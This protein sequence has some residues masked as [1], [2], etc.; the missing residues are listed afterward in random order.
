MKINLNI[1]TEEKT[2][3]QKAITEKNLIRPRMLPRALIRQASMSQGLKGEME[4]TEVNKMQEE[5]VY[6][7][8]K[9]NMC[10]KALW[11]DEVIEGQ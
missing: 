11:W 8:A 10:G 5:V 1:Q 4:L 7:K 3:L 2:Q 9:D 6:F